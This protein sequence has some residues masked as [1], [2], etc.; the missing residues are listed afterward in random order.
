MA[1]PVIPATHEVGVGGSWFEANP[2]KLQRSDLKKQA[3]CGGIRCNSSYVG[4]GG[5][6]FWLKDSSAKLV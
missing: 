4:G 1:K 6:K 3:E 2:E 5:R